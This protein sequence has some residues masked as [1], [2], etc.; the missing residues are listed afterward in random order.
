[1]DRIIS[2]PQGVD[3]IVPLA[4]EV[5]LTISITENK[6]ARAKTN[7]RNI[8]FSFSGGTTFIVPLTFQP[9]GSIIY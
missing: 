1:M 8:V 9:D 5:I 6:I 3:F 2:V 7:A 4:K